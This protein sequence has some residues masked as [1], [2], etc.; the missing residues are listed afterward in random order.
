M[1]TNAQGREKDSKLYQVGSPA[2]E[3]RRCGYGTCDISGPNY[4]TDAVKDDFK[5]LTTQ[6]D[7]VKKVCGSGG[8][9][10]GKVSY[11]WGRV[12]HA[13]QRHKERLAWGDDE[14]VAAHK[15]EALPRVLTRE[16]LN[17]LLSGVLK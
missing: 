6:L 11:D 10:Q 16:R 9:R 12:I 5:I 2:I 15:P 13:E 1:S 7:R 8:F 3:E 14:R 4:G 17:C